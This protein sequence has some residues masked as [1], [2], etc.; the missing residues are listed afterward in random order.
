[1]CQC[2]HLVTKGCWL[3]KYLNAAH[4][5]AYLTLYALNQKPELIQ[6]YLAVLENYCMLCGMIG[7]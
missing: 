5:C 4:P 6:K 3:W 2:D 1:M 7:T